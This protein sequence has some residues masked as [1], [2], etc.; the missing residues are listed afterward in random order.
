MDEKV[1]AM[2]I[3]QLVLN[4]WQLKDAKDA[5]QAKLEAQSKEKANEAQ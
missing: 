5:L 3:G 2:H 4:L 1:L